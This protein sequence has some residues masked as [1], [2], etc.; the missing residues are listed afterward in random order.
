M[1]LPPPTPET[2]SSNSDLDQSEISGMSILL[3]ILA[4]SIPGG[5]PPFEMVPSAP[6]LSR[7]RLKEQGVTTAEIARRLGISRA[8]VFRILSAP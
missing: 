3:Q 5:A 7:I 2:A 4:I 1:H 8:S 6:P